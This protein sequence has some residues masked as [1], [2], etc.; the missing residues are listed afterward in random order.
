MDDYALAGYGV[1]LNGVARELA[2]PHLEYTFAGLARGVTYL[3]EVDAVDAA[4]NRSPRAGVVVETLP[5]DVTP[6]SAPG[7]VS[8]V[9][10]GPYRV[11]VDWLPATDDVGVFA[12]GVY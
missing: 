11:T 1:Y 5:L 6:P 10:A 9:A 2:H 7:G 12:Y 3:V 8:V 4:G